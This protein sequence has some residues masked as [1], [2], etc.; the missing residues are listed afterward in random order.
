MNQVTIF[1][2][3]LNLI[4][5]KIKPIRNNIAHGGFHLDNNLVMLQ[6]KDISNS[7]KSKPIKDKVYFLVVQTLIV[8]NIL[9]MYENEV[10]MATYLISIYKYLFP[11]RRQCELKL[12]NSSKVVVP[13]WD[14][15]MED[16]VKKSNA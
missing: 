4:L 3:K 11:Q 8:S 2:D 7:E 10:E 5:S 1:I 9:E 14:A 12:K 16:F 13:Q 6:A 15:F